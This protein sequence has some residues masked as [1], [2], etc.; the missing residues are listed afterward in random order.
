MGIPIL[1]HMYYNAKPKEQIKINYMINT[2]IKKEQRVLLILISLIP[3]LQNNLF[4]QVQNTIKVKRKL[5]ETQ[6]CY[7]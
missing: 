1:I 7:A 3:C 6:F 5:L 4:Y 2:P